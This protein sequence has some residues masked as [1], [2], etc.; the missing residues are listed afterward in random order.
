MFYNYFCATHPPLCHPPSGLLRL[1]QITPPPL[2]SADLQLGKP[3]SYPSLCG[4]ICLRTT[5]EQCCVGPE[6]K[7]IYFPPSFVADF[8]P[9]QAAQLLQTGS[10]EAFQPPAPHAGPREGAARIACS[11][12]RTPLLE[13]S[14]VEHPRTGLR[15]VQPRNQKG[16]G[17]A[18]AWESQRVHSQLVKIKWKKCFFLGVGGLQ[19]PLSKKSFFLGVGGMP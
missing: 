16:L 19:V 5:W 17:S 18:G 12:R 9:C 8:Q 1:P 10:E 11:Y 15:C 6:K 4:S 3:R 13:V 14:C 7:H 2:G